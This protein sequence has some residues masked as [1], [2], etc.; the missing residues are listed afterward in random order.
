VSGA[1]SPAPRSSL[2][3]L[4]AS[5]AEPVTAHD[6]DDHDILRTRIVDYIER[7][8]F[9]TG[10]TAQAIARAH[11]ISVRHLYAILLPG[12]NGRPSGVVGV[13]RPLGDAAVQFVIAAEASA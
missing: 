10:L 4:V 6:A 3:A 7:H 2:S 12:Q 8:L 9:D 1:P 13:L 5:A 11:H